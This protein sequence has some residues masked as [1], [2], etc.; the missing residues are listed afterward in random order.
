MN[1]PRPALRR[2]RS[3][4]AVALDPTPWRSGGEADVY[5]C[6]G[7]VAKAF[8]QPADETTARRI[9]ALI[10]NRP[11]RLSSGFVSQAWAWPTDALV[12]RAGRVWGSVSPRIVG[13]CPLGVLFD[14]RAREAAFPNVTARH[15]PRVA[16]NLVELTRQT[17]ALG[18]VIGDVSPSNYLVS[19]RKCGVS[20]IDLES[21]QLMARAGMLRCRVGTP[22]YLAPEIAALSDYASVNRDV[23]QD[24]F[25][26]TAMVYQLLTAGVHFCDGKAMVRAGEWPPV[27]RSGRIAVGAWHG[28]ALASPR[29]RVQPPPGVIAY[30]GLG[31]ELG[32]LFR[33]CFDEGMG[34]PNARPSLA[35]L[36]QALRRY[37]QDLRVCPQNHRHAI[38]ASLRDCPW[39]GVVSRTSADPFPILA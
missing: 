8:R 34:D 20:L 26:V 2:L 5:L 25:G 37:E 3:G 4:Q 24:A 10:D 15:L 36:Q 33:R 39:C 19:P 31:P 14:P 1:S 29:V 22:D 6:G 17:H 11:P 23:R 13:A 30:E 7:E 9:E 16:Q 35:G 28:T 12:D 21:V 27:D 32:G 38:H 18:I